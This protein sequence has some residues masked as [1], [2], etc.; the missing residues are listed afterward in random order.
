M[1]EEAILKL[2]VEIRDAVK[3]LNDFGDKASE[4]GKETTDAFGAIKTA[5][6]G[7]AAVLATKEVV[8]FFQA[9]ID[10]AIA[11]EQAMAG[12]AQQLKLTGDFSQEALDG[13][14]KF[15]DEMER[16]TQFG[17]DVVIS[18]VAVA[19]SFGATNEQAQKLVKA[20]SE[21]SA[22]TGDSLES[23][24]E[25]LGKS[26]KGV[27]GKTPALRDAFKG[28][29]KSALEAGEGIDAVLDRFGGSQAALL[30]TFAGSIK[31]TENAFG[32][33]QEA[34]GKVIVEN[35][36]LIALIKAIGSGFREL[37]QFV[38]DNEDALGDLVSGGVKTFVVSIDVAIE[39]V[40]FFARAFEGL[41]G[42]TNIVI[43]TVASGFAELA[44]LGNK[45]GVV[46]D[47]TKKQLDL[48]AQASV[49]TSEEQERAFIKFN[50][51]FEGFHK[52]VQEYAQGVFDADQVIVSS[53]KK[54]VKDR[55][56][57]LDKANKGDGLVSDLIGFNGTKP[58]ILFSVQPDDDLR[59]LIDEG[60]NFN[61]AEASRDWVAD[62]ETAFVNGA[63]DFSDYL[64][65]HWQE[66]AKAFIGYLGNGKE[67][68]RQAV[69]DAAALGAQALGASPEVAGII[70]DA[71]KLLGQDPE[72]FRGMID[73]F[74]SGIPEI[75]DNIVQNIPVLVEALAEHSGEIITALVAA[76]P[77]IAVALAESMPIVAEAL[78]N[79][80][81][82]GLQYQVDKFNEAASGFQ[83][84][85]HEAGVDFSD[86]AKKVG[87]KIADYF[88]EKIPDIGDAFGREMKNAAGDFI[89]G[90]VS[91]AQQVVDAITPGGGKG[92]GGLGVK[93]NVGGYDYSFA[94]GTDY[95][96][97]DGIA[98][99]H[100]GE[101]VTPADTNAD[102]TSALQYIS[103]G[104]FA[105]DVA[106]SVAGNGGAGGG[107]PVVV[108]LMLDGKVLS[109]AIL[110]M[111][112]RNERL[113]A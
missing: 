92:S 105:A 34:F 108:Q 96:P 36:P 63:H 101:R 38:H 14:A 56:E 17:D 37:E 106:G 74:V 86:A 90:I 23:S 98:Q 8:D 54:A 97:Q 10:A 4:T 32:N 66:G 112:R 59:K 87:G 49:S 45:I 69:G 9:G 16:T 102:L 65:D 93:G 31:Q 21:L 40:G 39:A 1:S 58:E 29:S 43:D 88:K 6:A 103:S 44:D 61:A 11:Q 91:G 107:A 73:G 5:A 81:G 55:N 111:S 3:A 67:G 84:R 53:A 20:A 18:Q 64:K 78:A 41:I 113:R 77:R 71:F 76:T 79:E 46:S 57:A 89:D 104:N 80:V 15:A 52:K 35:K 19:K 60:L 75:I 62:L 72:A 7:I 99:I 51:G 27:A 50:E 12:L 22:V 95:V 94:D 26:L 83:D 2:G 70:G 68:A 13:F 100:K 30:D 42:V 85:V 109:S 47:D 28:L 82:D 110:D 25:Q 48:F 33:L 24:V